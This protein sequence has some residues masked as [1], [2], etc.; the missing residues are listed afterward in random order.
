MVFVVIG[1]QLLRADV[2]GR[3]LALT[4]LPAVIIFVGRFLVTRGTSPLPVMSKDDVEAA[5][6]DKLR[7]SH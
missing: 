2:I 3:F 6:K 5:A 4:P 1:L 7:W